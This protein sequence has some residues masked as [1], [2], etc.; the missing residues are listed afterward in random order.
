MKKLEEIVEYILETHEQTRYDDFKLVLKVY[1]YINSEVVKERFDV[2]MYCHK[3]Y[4]IPSFHSISR[5]RRKVFEKRPDLNPK[6]IKELREIQ[7][8]KYKE[9][10]LNS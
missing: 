2:V 6:K 8:Q 4:E 3:E 10:A 1:G 7:E 5:T 9:Y